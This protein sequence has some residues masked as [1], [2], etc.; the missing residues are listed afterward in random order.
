MSHTV[1]GQLATSSQYHTQSALLGG[2]LSTLNGA[3]NHGWWRCTRCGH[4]TKYSKKK[5]ILKHWTP[6]IALTW[7]AYPAQRRTALSYLQ[8]NGWL[9]QAGQSSMSLSNMASILS[10]S[11][12]YS[13]LTPAFQ[14]TSGVQKFMLLGADINLTATVGSAADR[15]ASAAWSDSTPF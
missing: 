1:S 8:F 2:K 6:C 4:P 13:Y 10:K 7:S 14:H 5:L 15:V 11:G 9:H 3:S 12:G